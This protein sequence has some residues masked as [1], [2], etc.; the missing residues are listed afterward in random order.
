M[1]I[2]P[3]R[4]SHASRGMAAEF[5]LVL[6]AFFLVVAGIFLFSSQVQ[7]APLKGY[8]AMQVVAPKQGFTM[9]P[10]STKQVMIGF[11]NIGQTTWA[12]SGSTYVSIYTYDPKYR[13]SDFKA[14]NWIDF[15]QAALL[16]E[17]SVAP[18][19]TGHIY[20]TL[21]A[22]LS[23]GQYQETFYLAAEDVAWIPGG[24]FTLT[25]NVGGESQTSTTTTQT[26]IISQTTD[27]T[28]TDGQASP[29]TDG[30]SAMVLL[31]SAKDL[32]A[33]AGETIHYTVGIKN[34]GSVIW[35]TREIRTSDVAMASSSTNSNTSAA[36]QVVM[37][38]SGTVKPGGLDFFKFSFAA[39]TTKGLHTVRYQ[40]VVNDTVIPD[41]SIDIPVEVT[42]G[43][44]A[45]INEPITVDESEIE[46]DRLIE[47]PII[48]I[49]LLTID[50]E[51]DW[52]TEIS[53]NTTWK[54]RDSE[55]GLLGS[56]G[57]DEMV[58]AFYKNQ[59]YYYNRGRGIEQTYKYLRF[60][61]DS[62]DGICTIENFD[63]SKT[64][65]AAYA[66]NQFRD[67]LELQYIP[68]KDET[69]VINE[70][71]VEEYLYGIA[72][73]SDYSHQEFKK[74]LLTVARTYALYHYERNSKHKGYFHMNSYADDQVYNGYGYEVR[75]PSIREA[76]D[77]TKGVTVNY[78]NATA[79]TPYFSRSDGRT[80]DW[81][82]V[83]GGSVA[84]LKS[85]PAP[86]DKAQGRT[87][88]GH[89][90]GMS[91]TEAL[92]MAEDGEGWE[93]ILHY[94]Y[95]GVELNQRWE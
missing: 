80:R 1:T 37:N 47:E 10:G 65:N 11:Q 50:E 34:T 51:T 81:S 26:S 9:E 63:R 21:H 17:S 5:L 60:I 2:L 53:C 29:E 78:N 35:T 73:T 89:G 72:E 15:T 41:F 69:W 16:D 79:L 7:A 61:P 87:L 95:T 31:R 66:D 62:V 4:E 44:A 64:R 19:Q 56:M 52:V 83:W 94:F 70:L 59:R 57:A 67:T 42:S 75:H 8:E 39:P 13:A 71:P 6:F 77:A 48:R 82:E 27:T 91:A 30:L 12:N 85:V 14:D 24:K 68:Y 88:W 20:L 58:R 49:G 38:S 74:A 54:L 28:T 25:I 90:V 93:D 32:K 84:W 23:K 36:T 92:D 22:P 86:H 46:A 45:V 43:S 3:T 33:K 76:V 55:G 40:M 18:N